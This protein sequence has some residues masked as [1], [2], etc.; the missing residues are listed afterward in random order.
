MHQALLHQPAHRIEDVQLRSAAHRLCGLHRA[1]AL[2]H[3]QATKERLLLRSK[4][5]VGPGDGLAHRPQSRRLVAAPARQQPQRV[6]QAPEQRLRREHAEARRRQLDPQW[7]PVQAPADRGDSRGVLDGKGEVRV[8]GSR[9]RDEER[10]CLGS[11]QVVQSDV[12][13]GR[14][15]RQWRHGD[16]VLARD[17]QQRRGS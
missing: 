7:Q 10:H 5:V 9:P 2:E 11:S 8:G 17:A 15:E 13:I 16:D 14:G 1:A 12:M 3:R 6:A 4:E